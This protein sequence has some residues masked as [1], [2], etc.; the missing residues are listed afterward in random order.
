MS[1]TTNQNSV[2]MVCID[3]VWIREDKAEGRR[4]S[5]MKDKQLKAILAQDLED[6][7]Q[8]LKRDNNSDVEINNIMR[9][10]A[11]QQMLDMGLGTIRRCSISAPRR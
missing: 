5:M 7:R 3:G 4:R 11:Y 2:K 6:K 9:T 1:T 10:D 8:R